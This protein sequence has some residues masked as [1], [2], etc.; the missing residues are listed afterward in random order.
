MALPDRRRSTRCT[1]TSRACKPWGWARL[2]T[3]LKWSKSQGKR[4]RTSAHS[5]ASRIPSSRYQLP[6]KY[7]KKKGK[8]EMK[9]KT[10]KPTV[11]ISAHLALGNVRIGLL[12]RAAE[13]AAMSG[14]DLPCG[15]LALTSRY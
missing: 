14:T 10:R 2:H 13:C 6:T 7:P 3:S 1:F 4:P 9:Q 11:T 15:V 8:T 5:Q 12:C